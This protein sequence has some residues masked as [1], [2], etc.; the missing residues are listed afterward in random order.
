M[1]MHR[2]ALLSALFLSSLL[3][4][5]ARCAPTAKQRIA[6]IG[7]G[8]AGLGA[9]VALRAA[10]MEVVVLEARGRIGGRIHTSLLWPDM[11]MDLG[12]SWIHGTQ[13]NPLVALA[14]QAGAMTVNTSFESMLLHIDP[15]LMTQG[16]GDRG[17][18]WAETLFERAMAWAENRDQDVSLQTALDAVAPPTSLDPVRRAQ[19]DFH[20]NTIYEQEYSGRSQ[21][22]SAQWMEEGESFGGDDALFPGGYSQIV[23]HLG[24]GLDIRLNHSV[25]TV[26]TGPTGVRLGLAD[27]TTL[28]AEHVLV[29]VPLG[30]LKAGSIAFDP[31][32]S[33]PKQRAIL[34]LG[35]GLLNKHCLRFDRIFWPREFDWHQYLSA[36]KGEW[37]EWVG[38]AKLQDTP[39][40]M[41]FSAAEHAEQVEQLADQDIVA[42]IMATARQMFGNAVPD[43]LDVQISRWRSDPHARGAYS[44]YATGSNPAD[45]EALAVTEAGRLHFAGEAQSRLYPGTVH[46]ALLSGRQAAAQIIVGQLR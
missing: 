28:D 3:P 13:G 40:L 12:A 29:T 9:A 8:I 31:P 14:R 32:L 22:L 42:S 1:M 11:P 43:P 44:F 38:L 33:A 25:E 27:G 35:M 45:R 26:T 20:V 23:N 5:A 10:G 36:R 18:E 41:V 34:R 7:A 24:N 37:A 46:G 15:A 6:V 4:A 19:L 21:Q 16:A 30:V 39:A 17:T 2:R